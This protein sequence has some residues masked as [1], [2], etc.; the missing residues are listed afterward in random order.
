MNILVACEE[1]QALT[2]A[3]RSLGHNAYSCDIVSCSG[4]HPEWHIHDD[5]LK[6]IHYSWDMLI[7]FP[8]CTFLTVAGNRHLSAPGRFESR[9]A[10]AEFFMEFVNCDHIPHRCIENPVG[11]MNTHYRKPDQIINPFDF[12]DNFSKRTCLWL[13]NLPL[14]VPD[15]QLPRPEPIYI[16]S[17]GKRRHFVDCVS[18]SNRQ[19]LRSKLSSEIAR[20]MAYQF[21]NNFF[22]LETLAK[23]GGIC[24]N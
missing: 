5:V 3:L 11:Y 6:Y 2:V 13:F 1:S 12:G 10:A 15:Y 8:P 21:T 19:Q 4:G 24:Y 16:Q 17:N 20:A 9:I 23:S 14:L 7:A 18:G 22:V